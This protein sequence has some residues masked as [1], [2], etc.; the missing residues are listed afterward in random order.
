MSKLSG[1]RLLLLGFIVVLLVA[2][3]LTMY[4]AQQQ[5][6]TKSGAQA[7]TKLTLTPAA[8]PSIAVNDK[9]TLTVNVDPGTNQVS[10][11]KFTITYDSTKL[12]TTGSGLTLLPWRT[13]NGQQFTPAIIQGPIYDTGTISEAI[14]VEDTPQNVIQTLTPIATID[15][16]ALNPTDAAPTQVSFDTTKTQVLSL[17]SSDQFNENVLST[18]IPADVTITAAAATTT[19][20]TTTTA[21]TTTSTTTTTAPTTTTT[22]TTTTIPAT[23][24]APA[25]AS[26]TVDTSSGSAPLAV[27]FT[28]AG[29][30][31][32]GTVSKVTF[33]FGDGTVQ[34]VTTGGNIG[35][36]SVSVPLA[37][38]YNSGGT[39]TASAVLTDNG[40]SQSSSSSCLQTINVSGAAAP[41]STPTPA[42]TSTPVVVT[43]T[44]TMAPTGPGQTIIFIGGLGAILSGIGIILLFAL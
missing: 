5:Q 39:F 15:F 31:P 11:V 27:N 33:N 43:P 17:G 10:Y 40:G 6:K 3:P 44:P 23:N 13:G 36:N 14:S 24:Q 41:T 26:L 25:C 21:T 9:I 38:T 42:P 29:T 18:T 20:T 2:I 30:D 19:T 32:D 12:A 34:D 8:P 28:A 1:K 7:A 37:H 16:S 35:T 4:M 22:T